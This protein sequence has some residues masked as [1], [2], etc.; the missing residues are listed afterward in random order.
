MPFQLDISV[1]ADEQQL[2]LVWTCDDQKIPAYFVDL[3]V[4]GR[5]TEQVRGILKRISQDYLPDGAK[6]YRQ[7][8]RP[9]ARA[10][11][12]LHNALFLAVDGDRTAPQTVLD[13]FPQERDRLTIFSEGHV[14]IPW[15][16]AFH[17]DP[18]TL[19]DPRGE[20]GDFAG[21][22]TSLFKINVR[23]NRTT[24]IIKSQARPRDNFRVLYALHKDRFMRACRE[25][26]QIHQDKIVHLLE[27]DVG[28]AMDWDKCKQK[29]R[30]IK[31]KDS[32]IYI[33]GHCDGA[34]VW[35]SDD[36]AAEDDLN[37]PKLKLDTS[38]FIT[39]FKKSPG[40]EGVTICFFNA[41]RT[42]AGLTGDGFQTVT[43]VAGFHGFIGS[44]AEITSNFAN[45][46]GMVFMERVCNEGF[47]IEEAFEDVRTKYFPL[48]LMYSCY[49][50]PHFRVE[51]A[52]AGGL[53]C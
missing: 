28:E 29:F 3:Q 33:F 13:A 16:F 20:I 14:Y 50:Y 12:N 18:D 39:T 6:D 9:L 1:F 4:V 23:L 51:G 43:S 35:L 47:S 34:L 48:S 26:D 44:E 11:A 38:D 49:A 52:P 37:G 21:F 17:A 32:I 31:D 8:L 25:L 2:R 36:P 15:S 5:A 10:G 53:P 27:Q 42:V 19:G 30:G 46:Y 22:W 24:R 7:F 40:S 41:C 45:E